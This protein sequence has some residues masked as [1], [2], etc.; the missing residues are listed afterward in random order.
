MY[1]PY[2]Y[3]TFS[4]PQRTHFQKLVFCL[5]SNVAMAL[6][7]RL[8]STFEIKGEPSLSH[9]VGGDLEAQRGQGSCVSAR[10]SQAASFSLRSACN[11][12]H[13]R[14]VV[15]HGSHHGSLGGLGAQLKPVT[16][17][18]LQAYVVTRR[19]QS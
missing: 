14:W 2:L 19:R 15:G 3:F 13:P 7:V 6:G 12:Y 16:T 11:T 18:Q 4:Y 9:G 10:P 1:L 17:L 8:I 5:L